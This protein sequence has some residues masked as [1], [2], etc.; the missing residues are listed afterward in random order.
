MH[1]PITHKSF[2]KATCFFQTNIQCQQD[3]PTHEIYPQGDKSDTI[4]NHPAA[5]NNEYICQIAGMQKIRGGSTQS[6]EH[7]Y[8]VINLIKSISILRRVCV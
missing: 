8:G 1:S 6:H 7:C 5:G 4:G 3:L 2:F